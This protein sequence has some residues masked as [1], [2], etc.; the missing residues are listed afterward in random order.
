MKTAARSIPFAP[1][2]LAATLLVAF[3]VL[4]A[5]LS[6]SAHD[7]LVASSPAA[8]STVETLPSEIT[9]TFSEKLITGD[10]AT[11]LVVTDASGASV[12]NG[13]ATVDGAIVTQPLVAGGAAGEYH[14]VWKIVSS[15]GHPTSGEFSFT[16]TT[17]TLTAPT[18]EPSPTPSATAA[19]TADAV[20]TQAADPA[21]SSGDAV[22]FWVLGIVGVLVLAAVVILVLSRRGNR[23]T[24][25]S[26]DLSAR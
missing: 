25:G 12:V 4:F 2:A 14:V 15:D 26:D 8:D 20:D 13:P 5:P 16:V 3:L 21:D 10:G 23:S 7:T 22:G 1:V 24:T 9:L 6:A 19:Q 11:E 17:S 18:T